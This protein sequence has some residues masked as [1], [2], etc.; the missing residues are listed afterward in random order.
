MLNAVKQSLAFMTIRERSK[1]LTFVAIRSLLSI[2]DLA[3]IMAIGF[4]VTSTAAF[5][6]EG[7]SP[8]REIDFVGLSIPAVTA[9]TLPVVSSGILI[10]FL[11][12][13]VLSIFVIRS[14]A[15]LV[16]AI[17]A[18]AAKE[19]SVRVFG[20]DLAVSRLKSRDEM[21][22]AI[23]FGSP[24]AFNSLLNFA[25]SAVAEGS[26][27]V[28]ICIAF[29]F[30]DPVST[31]AAI[32]YFTLIGLVMQFFV[33][34]RM[35]R[36]GKRAAESTIQANIVLGDLISVFRELS[37]LGLRNK[38]FDKLYRSRIAAADSAATQTYLAGMPRYIIESALL[39]G[40]TVFI[41]S[42]AIFA[43][44]VSSAS[45]I[46]VFLAGG[47][48]L[49]AAI[50]PLQS[51]FL[52]IRACMPAAA[53][54][55][56]ILHGPEKIQDYVRSTADSSGGI[57]TRSVPIQVELVNVD[58][59][60]ADKMV[61]AL[62]G[63]SMRIEPGQQVA[64]IGESGS[65]KSTIADLICGVL[66]PE[67]GKVVIGTSLQETAGS[68][69]LSVSYVPQSPGLVSGTVAENVALGR[70]RIEFDDEM[71]KI[72]LKKANLL[73]AVEALPKGVH[74]E[75]GKYQEG[76]SGG[77]IQRL[78]LAR[79]LYTN[80]GLLVM[81]EATS[82][83]DAESEAEI[84][85]ALDEM[86][87]DVTVVL[88]AHRLNTVQHADKV[89]LMEAGRLSDSGTFQELVNRNPSVKRTVRLMKVGND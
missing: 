57:R 65:G 75:L 10:A 35:V 19:I 49:T 5:L 24:A 2:L 60:Y 30:I 50:L 25:S 56:E 83:L 72:A 79:A 38:Y 36:S 23:Q 69:A 82:A 17:E 77:Q 22:Y 86:K 51:A 3:G 48:R 20:S 31:L 13:T 62:D 39:V 44:I 9:Q 33:G 7:S 15:F 78:G 80:P 54:A 29:L 43:D 76:F 61:R 68:S 4:V 53:T 27:F 26:L 12:K 42:Q 58:F 28:V 87:G 71:V 73:S 37:V 88:I 41:I 32:A 18:R 52:G 8:N 66:K 47:F 21:S 11:L 1:W 55:H 81:D 85:K 70:N 74:S 84:A 64:I 89:F 67:N 16:A 14:T 34:N 40:L 6:T 46:G 59:S 45:V 63:V